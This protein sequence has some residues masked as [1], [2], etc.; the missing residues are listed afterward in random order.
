MKS[1]VLITLLLLLLCAAVFAVEDYSDAEEHKRKT[2]ELNQLADRFRAETGFRGEINYSYKRMKLSQIRGN[3]ADL[4]ITSPQDTLFMKSIFERIFT[5]VT[6]YI[7]AR[8]EQLFRG[9]VV[10]NMVGA[11]VVYW[12]VVNGYRIEGGAG[13]LK[14][15]YNLATSTLTILD[16]TA[17]ISSE[18]IPIN[19]SVEQALQIAQKEILK[20][21]NVKPGY[22]SIAYTEGDK[23]NAGKYYLCHILPF[24]D[25]VVF[26][27]VSVPVI[28]KVLPN[29]KVHSYNV[30]V[31]GAVYIPNYVSYTFPPPSLSG[32]GYVRL[33]SPAGTLFADPC[34]N[35]II[36]DS[37]YEW[38]KVELNNRDVFHVTEY[39]DSCDKQCDLIE[40]NGSSITATFLDNNASTANTYYH[41]THQ[42]EYINSLI[43]DVSLMP[44]RWK[45]VTND[46]GTTGGT[47]DY[48]NR[49]IE[50]GT[51]YGLLSHIIRHEVS[52]ANIFSTLLTTFAPVSD[53]SKQAMDEA[54]AVYLPCAAIGSPYCIYGVPIYPQQ[55]N[56]LNHISS[57]VTL[58]QGECAYEH[59][60]ARFTIASA[61]WELRNRM[62]ETLFEQKLIQ[63]LTTQV[64]TDDFLRYRPRYFYNI[65]M[66]NS[67]PD[68]QQLIIEAYTRRGLHFMP[69]VESQSAAQKSR[70]SF[71]PG[72]Q[73]YVNITQAPQNTPF[74]V[75][76]IRHGDYTYINGAQVSTL[77]NHLAGGFIPVEDSTDPD[78]NWA[79]AV[80]TIPTTVETALGD[81]DIIVDFGDHIAPDNLIHFAF[82]NADVMDGFDGLTQPGIYP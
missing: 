61:W 53:V 2:N 54:F 3:F 12:Q 55:I 27:D 10:C 73:V 80:W 65:L 33:S 77:T 74:K 67:T 57:V 44:W 14:I 30:D 47:T 5:K 51:N 48:V 59:Y 69:K 34:G 43:D 23:E 66:R 35:Q 79:G 38:L 49:T 31:K 58:T 11:S 8:P 24:R 45:I 21:D 7:S 36:S 26:I 39:P 81:Y 70:N 25:C 52:H 82:T 19:V 13:T 37:V 46:P 63:G 75:Y 32:L 18:V 68:D 60:D 1:K 71:S 76:V 72:D 50:I 64:F 22:S 20:K 9:K 17:N 62:G 15:S 6:P 28:R 16:G 4:E 78:G 41:A 29:A 56:V 40:V 42:Q